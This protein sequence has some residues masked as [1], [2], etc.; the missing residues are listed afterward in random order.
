MSKHKIKSTSV[1][2]PSTSGIRASKVTATT[3]GLSFSFKYWQHDHPKFKATADHQY[4]LALCQRLKD[5]A[6]YM[7]REFRTQK[8]STLRNHSIR[9]T[10]TTENGFGLPNEEQLVDTPYQFSVSAT[11]H[12]RVHGFLINDVFYVVWLDPD[13]L[14]YA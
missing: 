10:A 7:A 8:N 9:W 6:G 4:W 2:P 1:P 14:L 12:G 3:G 5:L 11:E 13:H